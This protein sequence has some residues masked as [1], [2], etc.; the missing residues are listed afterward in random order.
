MSANREVHTFNPGEEDA[1]ER[2]VRRRGG[3]VLTEREE[4]AASFMLHDAEC[5]HLGISDDESFRFS[6][7]RRCS[8]LSRPLREWAEGETG[9]DPLKC[10][11]CW[12]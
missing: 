9:M 1:Y 8:E 11:S 5:S 4:D 3:Y 10:Q 2:W 12:G 7:P 6:G